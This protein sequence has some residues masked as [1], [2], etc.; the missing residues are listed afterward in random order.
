VVQGCEIRPRVHGVDGM[1]HRMQ[2]E[3]RMERASLVCTIEEDSVS[4]KTRILTSTGWWQ[5]VREKFWGIS[6]TRAELV[7]MG[8]D[9]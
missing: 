9:P 6:I 2:A 7:A 3:K 5:R 1:G 8:C 4:K